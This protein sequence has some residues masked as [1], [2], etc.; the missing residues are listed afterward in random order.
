[1]QDQQAMQKKL[2]ERRRREQAELDALLGPEKMARLAEYQKTMGSRQELAQVQDQLAAEDVPMQ[3]EQRRQL[4]SSI[5]EDQERNPHPSFAPGIAPEDLRAQI[6][7]WQN[8]R[9]QRLLDAARG[10]LTSKQMK[11]FRE[12]QEYQ[13]VMRQR[14]A[15]VVPVMGGQGEAVF[16]E[17]AGSTMTLSSGSASAVPP[18]K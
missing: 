6:D 1:M 7:E 8:G 12:Y 16:V 9:E 14:F 2:E 11:V 4:L 17:G 13:Q 5:V 15:S 3:P 10:V 18:G